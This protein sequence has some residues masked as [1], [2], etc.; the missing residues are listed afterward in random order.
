MTADW[1]EAIEVGEPHAAVV[2]LPNAHHAEAGRVV[3]RAGRHAFVALLRRIGVAPTRVAAPPSGAWE[4][5]R[6]RGVAARPPRR[7]T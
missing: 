2:C 5:V 3:F 6:R 7:A 1:R 4:I